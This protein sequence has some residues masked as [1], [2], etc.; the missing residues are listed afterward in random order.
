MKRR[1]FIRNTTL[2]AAGSVLV[3]WTLKATTH[4]GGMILPVAPTAN[5]IR[6]GGALE[7]LVDQTLWPQWLR[8]YHKHRFHADGI[9][10][11]SNDLFQH[12]IN[13]NGQALGLSVQGNR[14]V[15]LRGDA[16]IETHMVKNEI[17]MLASPSNYEIA[18][19]TFDRPVHLNSNCLINGIGGRFTVN[20]RRL[21]DNQMWWGQ[22]TTLTPDGNRPSVVTLIFHT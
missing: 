10:T 20:G 9:S 1:A 22:V 4:Q 2:T 16:S 3:P 7:S 15:L 14:A 5:H 12:Q 19:L 11:G 21:R 13:L 17:S 18:A 6:H 8:A